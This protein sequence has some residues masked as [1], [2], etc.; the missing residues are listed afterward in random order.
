MLIVY[1]FE[2]QDFPYF[3]KKIYFFSI[4]PGSARR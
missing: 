2:I 4:I 3:K 1:S